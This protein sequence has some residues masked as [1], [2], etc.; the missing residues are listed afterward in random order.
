MKKVCLVVLAFVG[1]LIVLGI[2]G[3]AIGGGES[4]PAPTPTPRGPAPTAT[5]T[6][7]PLEISGTGASVVSATLSEGKYVVSI[8]VTGNTDGYG[9]TNFIVTFG[10][11]LIVNEIASSWSGSSVIDV[12]GFWIEA[13]RIPVEIEAAPRAQWT[14]TIARF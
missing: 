11:D 8:S 2:V 9:G 6:P 14:M 3:A 4:P 13:G 5:P 7:K 10:N 12:G 1:L